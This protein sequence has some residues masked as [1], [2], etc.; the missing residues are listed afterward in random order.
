MKKLIWRLVRGVLLGGG[1]AGYLAA[2]RV[3]DEAAY[4]PFQNR[5]V[6]HRGLHSCGDG[7]VPENSLPAFRAACE[8]DYGIELDVQLSADGE[9]V[10]FHDD[11]LK[12]V[13][14]VDAP[15]VSLPLEELRKLSLLGSAETIPLFSEVLETVAGRVPL[16][17]ELKNGKRN[18]ELCEKTL[19]LLRSY[20]G[21]YCVES[22]SPTI[23]RWFRENAPEIVR[24]QLACHAHDYGAD[25]DIG[26]F[27][28]S[29]C[30][31]NVL[32]RPHFIAYDLKKKPLTVQFAELLGAKKVCW[33]SKHP[34]DE[35]GQDTVIF[36]GYR[37]K[38]RF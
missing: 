13:C 25:S 23:V 16:I 10:V 29:H 34:G 17:V 38:G 2:P 20:D 7:V 6:A 3:V 21:D 18:K 36:E 37:P 14:G 31:L 4:A 27:F 5:Y 35:V 22:F 24:G 11:D 26:P 32:S 9:V 33:T 1:T 12:R 28:L 15:V 19:K 8:E 30:L